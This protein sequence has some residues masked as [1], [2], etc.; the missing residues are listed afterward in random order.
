MTWPMHDAGSTTPD[1][2]PEEARRQEARR[3][4]W[5]EEPEPWPEEHWPEEPE[6]GPDDADPPRRGR[7]AAAPDPLPPIE[8]QMPGGG[9]SP[10]ET[11][12]PLALKWPAPP[13]RPTRPH[14]SPPPGPPGSPSAPPG[15][16]RVPRTTGYPPADPAQPRHP[17]PGSPLKAA[18][19]ARPPRATGWRARRGRRARPAP[20]SP[21][22]TQRSSLVRSGAGMAVGTLVSRATGFL[23]TLVLV[24]AL[25]TLELGN[26]YNNANTLPNSVYYLMLGG[27][28]TAVVVPLL[29][30][31]AQARP[32][33]RR[34]LRTALV[35]PGH[36]GVARSHRGGDAPGRSAGGPDRAHH[37]RR[38][39]QP[40]GG[41]GLLLHPADLLLRHQ[42]ADRGDP[43]HPGPVRGADVGPGRQQPGRDRHRRA[44]RGDGGP[45]QGSVEH[46][47][48]RS[49]TARDRH[50]AGRRGA[51]RRAVPFAAGGRVQVAAHA[52]VPARRGDRDGPDGRLDVGL[53]HRHVGRQP[54]RPDR[55]ERGRAGPER[56]FRVRHRLAALPAALRDHRHLGDH[57]AAAPDERA[58]QRAPVLAGQGRL[59]D[60]RPAGLGAR[61]PGGDLPR[62]PRRAAGRVPVLLRQQHG[63]ERRDTSAR[64]SA[65]SPSA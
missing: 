44:L 51:D 37:P 8:G 50:H 63:R 4:P 29:V 23:R 3:E 25:G 48:Q 5:P 24:Y 26:A 40:D 46:L 9:P 6:P 16:R 60:R 58:R 10:A 64:S 52:R 33:P 27:I 59:L 30:R 39:A 19:T 38:R 55:L 12:L 7:H 43:E 17:Q 41:L 35:H 20:R 47:G 42:L 65:C 36:A 28:F 11:T 54:G 2:G 32:G 31:A 22:A 18:G 21:T 13:A 1:P 15:W 62:R 53:R 61:G 34:G 57:G 56:L 14:R 49:A 45:E